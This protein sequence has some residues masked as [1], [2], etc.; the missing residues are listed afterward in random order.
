M[1]R[2]DFY[3][4]QFSLCVFWRCVGDA[5]HRINQ[6]CYELLLYATIF[7]SSYFDLLQLLALV[8]RLFSSF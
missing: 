5:L 7:F 6:H 1:L 3:S 8:K 2:R 4:T